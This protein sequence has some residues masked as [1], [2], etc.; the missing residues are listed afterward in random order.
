MHFLKGLVDVILAD[1][2]K[3]ASEGH[4]AAHYRSGAQDSSLYRPSDQSER[5]AHTVYNKFSDLYQIEREKCI[6][7]L[8][9]RYGEGCVQQLSGLLKTNAET[10]QQ[11]Q[12]QLKHSSEVIQEA[13]TR[14]EAAATEHLRLGQEHASL[15][16][17]LES[18]NYENVNLKSQLTKAQSDL[19]A[20]KAQ[21]SHLN[22]LLQGNKET[23]GILEKKLKAIDVYKAEI[24][25]LKAQLTVTEAQVKQMATQ[26]D[27][28]L[29]ST[30]DPDGIK[31]EL[32]E[33]LQGQDRAI[34]IAKALAHD[35]A[36]LYRPENGHED[37]QTEDPER[38]LGE[39]PDNGNDTDLLLQALE[40]S[41]EERAALEKDLSYLKEVNN[42]LHDMYADLSKGSSVLREQFLKSSLQV[43]ETLKPATAN[44][45]QLI[46]I[47]PTGVL[48]FDLDSNLFSQQ[49]TIEHQM[50]NPLERVS[51]EPSIQ[52][53]PQLSRKRD[54]RD[55]NWDVE[56]D[57]F[58]ESLPRAQEG[59]SNQETPETP[60]EMYGE[61]F[62]DL[63]K[64][65]S[66]WKDDFDEILN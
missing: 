3:D 51:P 36:R 8:I 66:V 1:D 9:V 60:K 38:I 35:R 24:E 4:G 40:R 29:A 52:Q 28:W 31:R 23:F 39:R 45:V 13:N 11:L 33:A 43:L 59:A 7:T 44:P 19:D 2:L 41:K 56:W 58:Q 46:F 53:A 21:I 25:S 48:D 10:I 63:S 37:P 55:P 57:S 62:V 5:L 65:A 42:H 26:R 15:I 34:A 32:Q 20:G 14:I 22:E 64:S 27:N 16:S 61:E 50:E 30:P 49:P 17:S 54:P 6:R 47:Q 18:L 12:E